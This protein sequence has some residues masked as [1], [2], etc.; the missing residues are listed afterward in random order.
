MTYKLVASDVDG[1]LI[2]SAE[3]I[4][5]RLY[6]ALECTNG[7]YHFVIATGRPA[8][9][10]IPLVN[11]LPF[12]PV[13]ICANGA[14]VYDSAR[15]RI[16]KNHSIQAEVLRAVVSKAREV[17]PVGVA[18]ERCGT[19][20]LDINQGCYVVTEDYAHAWDSTEHS[21]VDLDSALAEPAVKLLLRYEAL[22]APEL[23]DL[24]RPAI[25]T[26]LVHITYS[27]NEGLLEVSA[28]NITKAQTLKELCDDMGIAA[29]DVLAFGDM[30]NDREMIE[31][32]GH[33]VAMANAQQELRACADEVTASNDDDGVARILERV[34]GE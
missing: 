7:R 21:V 24:I 23:F 16:I 33:G 22:T 11:Q 2:N 13:C 10:V 9:W 18:V 6:R 25:P 17:L 30:R 3:R 31:W 8:R 4:S 27:I 12:K 14:V 20:V 15:D 29:K 32:A 26:D 28:P 19:S 5:P 34:F 1:T